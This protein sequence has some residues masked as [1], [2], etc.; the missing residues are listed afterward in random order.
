MVEFTICAKCGDKI[1]NS[2]S[3]RSE[4]LIKGRNMEYHY[5]CRVC[6]LNLIEWLKCDT[7]A[8]KG[9]RTDDSYKCSDCGSWIEGLEMGDKCPFCGCLRGGFLEKKPDY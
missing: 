4:I 3:I 1:R 5:F 6:T 2:E 7:K 8:I 9:T